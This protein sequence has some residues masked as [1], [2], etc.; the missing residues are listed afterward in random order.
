MHTFINSFPVP[1][2]FVGLYYLLNDNSILKSNTIRARVDNL[3][4]F[5]QNR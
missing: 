4:S 1:C 3:S 5:F 2:N